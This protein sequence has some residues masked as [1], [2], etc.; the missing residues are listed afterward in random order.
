[1]RTA[2]R[3]IVTEEN[4][5]VSLLQIDSDSDTTTT[6]HN[7]IRHHVDI[8]NSI[9]FNINVKARKGDKIFRLY[10]HT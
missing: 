6:V 4:R 8:M 1:M 9:N 7:I 5:W 2:M 3:D 10:M